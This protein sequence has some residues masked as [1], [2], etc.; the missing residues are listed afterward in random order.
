MEM[1]ESAKLLAA[2][3]K[4]L[5]ADFESIRAVPHAGERG[6]ETQNALLTFLNRH[7]PKRFTATSGFVLDPHANAVSPHLDAIIYDQLDALIFSPADDTYIIPND[8]VAAV[9]EVKS[10]LSK[11]ELTDAADH[12]AA[13]KALTKLPPLPTDVPNEHG[14]LQLTGTR[15]IVFAYSSTTSL[16]S[17]A[18]NLLEI[19]ASRDSDLW[20][21]E[22]VVLGVGSISYCMYLP[23]STHRLH[24][25]GKAAPQAIP[26]PT[27]VVPEIATTPDAVLP[28]FMARLTN[29]LGF[30]RRRP[31]VRLDSLFPQELPTKKAGVYWFT[32]GGKLVPVPEALRTEGGFR[33]RPAFRFTFLNGRDETIGRA[34]WLP[35]ADGHIWGLDLDYVP[36]KQIVLA[37]LLEPYGTQIQSLP[38]AP[39]LELTHVLPGTEPP[40]LT[41]T[42]ATLTASTMPFHAR[43]EDL[44][45]PVPADRTAGE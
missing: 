31:G 16:D 27:Y 9:I 15:G 42:V 28:A 37:T 24:Y 14:R 29:H 35:W 18:D 2:A 19:N 38:V 44:R 8:N 11:R 1:S 10:T 36:A 39:G 3:G 23:G 22:I 12:I 30:Y 7:M 41:R 43:V 5:Q 34:E 32:A 13:A 4:R 25:G 20:L 21:D 33:P 45:A 40:N 17:I 26:F 6:R